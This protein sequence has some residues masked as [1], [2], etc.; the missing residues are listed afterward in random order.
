VLFLALAQAGARV[1]AQGQGTMNNVIFGT[2]G[3]TYYE[4]LG[5]GQGASDAGDGPAGVHVGMSNTMNTPVEVVETTLPLR[6]RTYALRAG[7]GGAGRFRGGDGVIREVETLEPCQ[8]SLLTERRARGP[9]GLAGGG[10]GAPGRNLVDGKDVGA[11]TALDL[12]A[13]AVVRIETP[14]GGGFGAP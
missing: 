5:G 14:G 9:R 10:D 12:P 8:L 4:T 13:G 11:K 7:S 2:G 1:P 3:W 6:V